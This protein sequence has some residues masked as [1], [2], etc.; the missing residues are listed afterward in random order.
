[1]S[2]RRSTTHPRPSKHAGLQVLAILLLSGCAREA[3]E[4]DWARQLKH[5]DP[6]VRYTAV[7]SLGNQGDQ[8]KAWVSALAQMLR[9]QDDTVRIGT[10]YALARIGPD[11]ASAIP[12]LSKALSDRN[13]QVR[14]GA[15]YALPAMGPEA[16]KAL[17][18]LEQAARDY[19][20][21]VRSQAA[22]S[23]KQIQLAQKF[24]RSTR[25]S[26]K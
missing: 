8:G 20:P 16:Q 18:S 4:P 6:K 7:Q 25:A 10:V 5:A 17:P 26:S 12:S 21:E 22:K 19:D 13:K 23:I 15:A 11:G 1:M 3:P 9:D 24:Q 14:V 2:S